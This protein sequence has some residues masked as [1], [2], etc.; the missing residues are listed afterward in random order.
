MR[1]QLSETRNYGCG[2][3]YVVN[4][5]GASTAEADVYERDAL[6]WVN[7]ECNVAASQLGVPRLISRL[8]ELLSQRIRP[9]LDAARQNLQE[10]RNQ[11][12]QNDWAKQQQARP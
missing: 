3:Y 4:K 11:L 2:V 6:Q 8:A 1:R 12:A 10:Q 9:V 7:R 5:R